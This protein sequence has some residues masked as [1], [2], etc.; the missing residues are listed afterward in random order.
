MKLKS[1]GNPYFCMHSI[2][3]DM[4][5]GKIQYMVKPFG[6]EGKMLTIRHKSIVNVVY[7]E[8]KEFD[9]NRF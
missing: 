4:E 7:R 5:R 1:F 8:G 9:K 2:S 6:L 3:G